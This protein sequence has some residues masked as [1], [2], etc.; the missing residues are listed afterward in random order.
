MAPAYETVR[1]AVSARLSPGAFAHCERVAE[2][3]SALAERY[4]L[5]AA[6]AR[7]AGLLHDWDRELPGDE[8]VARA[9]ALGIEVTPADEAVP[10]LLHGPVAERE[11]PA[12]F[13]GLSAEVLDAIGA[14][15]YGAIPMAPL[16]MAVY[17]ADV[18]EPAREHRGVESIRERVGQCSLPELFA[19]AYASSL[20]HVI[21]R[22]RPIHPVTLTV[23]NSIV[24]GE[25]A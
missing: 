6:E 5:D 20:R 15:T 10:Y 16:A 12:V 1:D 7:L 22:R 2:T 11:L 19:D 23:W 24:A 18:I 4:N 14:H 8:L 9:R 21:K 17:V 25:G 3:A 13:P